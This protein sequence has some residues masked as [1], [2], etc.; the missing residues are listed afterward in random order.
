MN[1]IAKLNL[2]F[3]KKFIDYEDILP[4]KDSNTV[5]WGDGYNW[6]DFNGVDKFTPIVYELQEKYKVSLTYTKHN[7]W[8]ASASTF[9]CDA[10]YEHKNPRYALMTILCYLKA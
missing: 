1:D 10:S 6:Y 9:L 5:S 4:T 3:V 7:M 2:E 8:T